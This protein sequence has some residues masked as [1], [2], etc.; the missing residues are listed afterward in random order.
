M[1]TSTDSNSSERPG[2]DSHRINLP[3]SGEMKKRRKEQKAGSAVRTE[4]REV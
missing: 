4:N 3:K 1:L 2:I